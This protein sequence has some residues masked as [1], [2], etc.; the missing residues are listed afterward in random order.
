MKL[1]KTIVERVA[2]SVVQHRF[3]AEILDLRCAEAALFHDAW[4]HIYNEAEQTFLT[5]APAGFVCTAVKFQMRVGGRR[6]DLCA[7]GHSYGEFSYAL[8]DEAKD[9][10]NLLPFNVRCAVADS[11]GYTERKLSF[12][13]DDVGLPAAVETLATKKGDLTTRIKEAERKVTAALAGTTRAK[14]IQLW[15]EIEPFLPEESKPAGL[16]ALPTKELNALLDL[17]V[18]EAA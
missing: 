9:Q 14:A 6:H 15:P 5:D 17:P 8:N 2:R 13:A 12:A 10:L 16:P 18:S 4:K 7:R 1:T 3:S 11:D